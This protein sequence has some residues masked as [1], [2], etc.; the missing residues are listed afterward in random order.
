MQVE[1]ENDTGGDAAGGRPCHA[2]KQPGPTARVYIRD[3]KCVIGGMYRDRLATH[4]T[5]PGEKP[6]G[7]KLGSIA[8]YLSPSDQDRAVYLATSSG[9]EVRSPDSLPSLLMPRP[10][11]R[12]DVSVGRAQSEPRSAA[13]SR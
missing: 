8:L 7:Y 13:L 9:A 10:C 4:A 11:A 2:G 3:S 6:T 1:D 12:A 5:L